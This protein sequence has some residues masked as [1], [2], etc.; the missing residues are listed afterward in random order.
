MTR[1]L[2]NLAS[3]LRFLEGPRWHEGR[4]YVSD[5][6]LRRVMAFDE[7]GRGELICEVPRQPSGLGFDGQGKLLI[8]SMLDRRVVRL[9]ADG[10]ETVA[11][12]ADLVGGPLND[13][14]VD[15]A[16]RIYVGN[17]GSDLDAGEPIT[18]T[19]L[20]RV[21]PDGTTTVVA[22]RLTFPNGTPITPDGRTMLV[23]ESFAFRIS[24]FDIDAD[25]GLSNRREWARFG[26]PPSQPTL[27]AVLAP[28]SVIPDGMVMDAEGAVWVADAR[29]AGALR[30]RDGEIVDRVELGADT[31]FA[32]ALGGEDGR[33]LFLCAGPPLGEL[34]P[35]EHHRASLWSC[36]VDVPGIG[37][38]A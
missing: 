9:G 37:F 32:C 28:G 18:P 3:G 25:G 12:L 26:E 2:K 8:S 35:K 33:T 22:D 7:Q 17:F 13:M 36:R 31:A 14:L 6:Y 4:L 19:V 29:G 1:E 30:V 15:G 21:D 27:E 34:D 23:A 38:A 16:G 11:D 5:F 24:A 10:L 20:V